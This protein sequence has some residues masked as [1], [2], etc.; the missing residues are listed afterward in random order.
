[1]NGCSHD[2]VNAVRI[3]RFTFACPNCGADISLEIALW[4]EA[5]QAEQKG[6]QDEKL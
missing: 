1:M 5:M 6:N 4:K 2:Y 3:G